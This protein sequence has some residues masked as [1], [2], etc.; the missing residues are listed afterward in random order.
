[1]KTSVRFSERFLN[2]NRILLAAVGTLALLPGTQAGVY[3]GPASG[4]WAINSNWNDNV[5]PNTILS[6]AQID[7][8]SSQNSEVFVETDITVGSLAIG[9]GDK[10]VVNPAVSFNVAGGSIN[11]SGILEL[12]AGAGNA[13]LNAIN[14]PI[15]ITG[16]GTLFMNTQGAGTA[17]FG[18]NQ[19]I[20]NM[21]NVIEGSG[22]LPQN[23]RFIYNGGTLRATTG[24]F[25]IDPV[26]GTGTNDFQNAGTL[27]ANAGGLMQITGNGGGDVWNAGTLLAN[28][29]EIQ[30]FTSASI[31]GGTLQTLGTGVIRLLDNET[32]YL[33]SVNNFGNVRI[34]NNANM[35]IGGVNSNAGSININAG[36]NNSFIS[37]SG[38]TS[39]SGNGVITLSTTGAGGA[40][41]TG[42]G[43]MVTSN[44]IQGRGTVG[45]NAIFM[46]NSGTIVAN[47]PGAV[48]NV[49]PASG[50]ANAGLVNTGTLLAAGGTLNLS[51]N[52]NG[53]FDNTNGRIH[54]S[55]SDVQLVTT[56]DI[57]GGTLMTS[58]SSA[59][60]TPVNETA[61]L[62][63]VT[64]VG[65]YI[66]DNNAI[67]YLGG[68]LTNT[69]TVNLN[70]TANFSDLYIGGASVA[71]A[72]SGTINMNA[73]NARI[74][75]GSGTLINNT[76][77]RGTGNVLL[78]SIYG[79][80]NSIIKADIGTSSLTVDPVAGGANAGLVNNGTLLAAGGT[81][82]LTGNG[83][84]FIDNGLT[85]RI[86]ASTSDVH[87]VTG[88]DV[89]N[90]TLMT[91]G[92]SAVRTP[93]N[94]TANLTNVTNTGNYIVD[95]NAI[96]Y[97]G[98]TLTNTGTVNLN[99]VLNFADLNI[100]GSSVTLAGSGT[101]NMNS[102]NAR[103]LGGS[104]TL[105]NTT[106]I[107]GY[108]QVL[109]NSLY[110]RN[111]SVI[112][113]DVAGQSLTIDPVAGG[114]NAGMV[115]NG[116]LLAEGGILG[117]SGNGTGFI[118][119]STGIINANSTDV[120]LH[121]GVDIRGG[122]LMTGAT[123][124]VR[125]PA[126]HLA[127]LT[128]V[129]NIGNLTVDNNGQLN[130]GA[131]FT[132]TGT[133]NLNAGVNF[134]DIYIGGASVNLAGSGTINMNGGNSRMY[135][136]S[137]T[138]INN[139]TI[140]G[141]GNLLV[142]T[143]Y[144]INNSIIKAD[145]GTSSLTIDPINGGA[146]AGLVNNGTLLAAG[147]T[148]NLNGNGFGFIDNANGRI[149]AS[150]S[151]VYFVTGVDIRNGTLMSSGTAVNRV[152]SNQTAN[153]T[154]VTNVGNLTV[155][156]AAQLNLGGTFTNTGTVNF[157]AAANVSDLYIG[158]ASVTLA[159]SG[160]INMNG[161]NARMLGGSGTLVNNT[162]IAGAGN[163]G[164]NVIYGINNGVIRADNPSGA[165]GLDAIN[166]GTVAGFTNNGVLRAT[167]GG[168]LYVSG[169]GFGFYNGTGS[170]DVAA[171]SK[172]T[173]DVGANFTNNAVVSSGTVT[174]NS[175]SS[176]SISSITGGGTLIASNSSLFTVRSN[177]TQ[178][179]TSKVAS[180]SITTSSKLDLNDN[181]LVIDYTGSSPFS[182]VRSNLLSGYNNGSWNG[183]GIIS[184]ASVG[185][186]TKAL[187]YA[188]A[189]A[190]SFTTTFR[191]QSF[192]GG[193]AVLVMQT[194]RGDTNLDRTVTS[195]DFNNFASG[196]GIINGSANWSQG[197]FD[198]N[199]KVNTID[200][201]WLAGQFGQ[202]LPAAGELPGP[203]LGSVVP[204][205]GSLLVS[206]LGLALI[207]RRRR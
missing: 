9:I 40:F 102:N 201:N 151:D 41:I 17:Y 38:S 36:T 108:G 18:G 85:G 136:G 56:V 66:V 137:G 145:I 8:N 34:G 93:N 140:R 16:T 124:V 57:R 46:V 95:N 131:T 153:M 182:T 123:G 101:I 55:T 164:V 94:E 186:P 196:Y 167:G 181:A 15:Y 64:N 81:L 98:G 204:E 135:G 24:T 88:V 50:G 134:S 97:L 198:Y 160:T 180:L 171:G 139:T 150:T 170:V 51:G 175:N 126:N 177:G 74:L 130:L 143:A 54:A 52:G 110:S 58:G 188:E 23:T 192:T 159:G 82:R 119:N 112:R 133:V 193:D 144:G 156:N 7:G 147:G 71:L 178:A 127:N 202:T 146:V 13:I 118:D 48:L 185:A 100:G 1:M 67:T 152:P 194:L 183:N 107:R 141:T 22:I 61:S 206:V 84:G 73:G 162:T 142:N 30:L 106:T 89:R 155:D 72:G 20:Y 87:L 44:T 99:A 120:Q 10:L 125:V 163:I 129:T 205:P 47:T 31:Q 59:V 86:H 138:L 105:V 42:S 65:N 79:I 2:R 19:S 207:Q 43:T 132:N 149:H 37:I 60:R 69:G 39:F 114:V 62:T 25:Y 4:V 83:T 161:G 29:A 96:T 200:F 197:D 115:N 6:Y 77:I 199:G 166:G 168:H 3:V 109:V 21:S 111:N 169:N 203:A 80:N 76:T 165:L 158:G 12:K 70:P 11:N 116:T 75:G 63:N 121:T 27:G 78:N 32:G 191:G 28:N 104:G 122:T 190:T 154:N 187:G 117:L 179:A 184:T 49:D 68:T 148:L 173:F 195:L 91:S 45:N 5:V 35:V 174:V 189:S 26:S 128:S 103:I 176:V 113:A 33:T 172:A 14:T 53:F 90:G 157:N 92:S